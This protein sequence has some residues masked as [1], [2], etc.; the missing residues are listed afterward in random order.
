MKILLIGEYSRLH[1]TLKKGL[2]SSG[3]L[4]TLVGDG[5]G[6]KNFPVD[7]S[8]KATFAQKWYINWFRQGIYRLFKFDLVQLESGIRFYFILNKLKDFDV[9]QLINERPIKT[10]AF[11]ERYLLK[12]IFRQ[13]SNVFLLSCG[14][15]TISF[16]Y[17]FQKKLPYSILDP[18]FE[19]S[20]LK[21]KFGYML[22]YNSE[23]TKKTHKL[24]FQHIKGVIATDMDYVI[25]LRDHPKFLGLIPNPIDFESIDYFPLHIENQINVFLGVN[26]GTYH[27][28]GI[29]FFEKALEFLQEKYGNQINV[30]RA[31]NIPYA[32]YLKLYKEAH[33]LLDQV[34]S[35]DQGY[36]ALEAMAQGKVVFTGA[37]KE[38]LS[39][40][41]LREEE[42]CINA[43][44][45]VNYLIEK[46]SLLIED[47]DKIHQ[48][49]ANAREF[50]KKE[51]DLTKISE[52]YLKVWQE[53]LSE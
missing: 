25:P 33:I 36:N 19:N 15:D 23:A 30:I 32:S 46:L 29:P 39:H 4:V 5:D 45:E 17:M 14:V 6:F 13:N 50:V 42:V 24:V 47:P 31:E 43:L 26:T 18:Y 16:A 11:L 44:P 34:Y 8:V 10:I 35:Y 2:L 37:E 51:H 48:I 22:E 53:L 21:E 7:I 41:N 38:F 20:K 40:Y 28:K 9:V 1:N 12:H 49:G 52:K 27:A 3:H